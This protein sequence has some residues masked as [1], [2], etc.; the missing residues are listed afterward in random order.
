M[1]VTFWDTIKGQQLAEI[2]IRELP[3][4]TNSK[5]QYTENLPDEEVHYFLE[6]KLKAGKRY[7]GHYSYGGMTTIIMEK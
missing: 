1:S 5:E 7:I 4:L 6:K 3:K 2:L